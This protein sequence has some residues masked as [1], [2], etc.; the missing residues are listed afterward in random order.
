MGARTKLNSA[1]VTGSLLVAAFVGAIAGSWTVFF[2][3][4]A[5]LIAVSIGAGD[6]RTG[7]RR[8]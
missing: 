4:A 6:I 3:S 7:R 8:R 5:V 2:I 1:Y